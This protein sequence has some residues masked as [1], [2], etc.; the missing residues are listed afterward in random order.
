MEGPEE[1][2]LPSPHSHSPLPPA[3]L[4]AHCPARQEPGGISSSSCGRGPDSGA[5]TGT[6]S[7][8]RPLPERAPSHIRLGLLP[9]GAPGTARTGRGFGARAISPA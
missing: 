9:A 1:G 5:G 2:R 8:A 7:H 3:L 4:T 6:H